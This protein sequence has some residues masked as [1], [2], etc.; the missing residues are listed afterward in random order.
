[1]NDAVPA[2]NFVPP[3]ILHSDHGGSAMSSSA[4]RGRIL[5]FLGDPAKLGDKAWEYFEDGLLWIEHG[6]VRALD[7][8]TYLLPQLPADLPLEEHPQR[9]LLPGF[10]D[11]HVHYPQLGVIASY[12]TQLLDWLETHTF[13]AEQRFADAGYAAAQ[14]ELFLDELLR[15]GTTTALVFGTVHA[16]SA[17]AFFQ[18]AQKRR[19]R[20]IAGKVLMDRNAPPALCDTA[21]SGYAESRALIERWHGNGRLQYAVTP[22]FAPTSSPEQLAAAARLLDEYP[23]VY[24]HTHLSEN[25]KEVAWVGELFPQAQDYLDV[26]HRAGL[27]GNFLPGRE[28][29]FVALDLA[30]T[31]MIAQRMEHARGLADT[32]FVL[33]TLGDDRAVAETWVM[34]ERRHV[35]G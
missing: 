7:H 33:N 9:L 28:A 10:V 18:A 22:R 11:C 29:D 32:L 13:P 35:K 15:H 24:L 3:L 6:H 31:P 23:G 12:G 34:G 19:L 27:V 20:M 17:E 14:A 16:V 26:Y 5:H 1:M 21:A 8:A 2:G 25:L 30:A 4:H